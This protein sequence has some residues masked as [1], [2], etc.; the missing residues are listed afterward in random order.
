MTLEGF[1][2][3]VTTPGHQH[4]KLDTRPQASPASREGT[5]LSRQLKDGSH[6]IN[7]SKAFE[8]IRKICHEGKMDL[9]S[10]G[11]DFKVSLS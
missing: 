9:G 2:P 10:N 8:G 6:N 4:H 1:F 7:V 3:R 5:A 11:I